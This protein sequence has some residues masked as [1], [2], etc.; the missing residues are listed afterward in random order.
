MLSSDSS[1]HP[2]ALAS[3]IESLIAQDRTSEV[4]LDEAQ[5]LL[6]AA[7]RLYSAKAER[8]GIFPAVPGGTITAT[9]AMLVAHGLL[10]AVNIS[11]FELGLW[12]SWMH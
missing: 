5:R 12:Q 2:E 9:D 8:D 6:A 3:Y 4:D 1:V 7:V 10:Q 11:V